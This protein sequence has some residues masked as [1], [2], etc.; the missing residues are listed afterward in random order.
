MTHSVAGKTQRVLS[1]SKSFQK[2]CGVVEFQEGKE[3]KIPASLQ[4]ST[5]KSNQHSTKPF[6]L[7]VNSLLTDGCSNTKGNARSFT[8]V[9]HCITPSSVCCQC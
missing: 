8:E 9:L 2:N 6:L 7:Q 5:L 3:Y 1:M 4:S